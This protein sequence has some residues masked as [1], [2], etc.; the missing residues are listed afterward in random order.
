MKRWKRDNTGEEKTKKELNK[1]SVF[2]K[3]HVS[4]GKIKLTTTA[5]KYFIIRLGK[6]S[7]EQTIR[8]NKRLLRL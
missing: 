8:P 4:I 7:M 1:K 5:N 3:L 6:R 2:L